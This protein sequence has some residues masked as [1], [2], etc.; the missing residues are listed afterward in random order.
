M[1]VEIA[2]AVENWARKWGRHATIGWLP[3]TPPIPQVRLTLKPDDGRLSLYREGRIAE[4]PVETV[5]LV[6]W[7]EA[8]G[9]YVGL[10]LMELG[11]G[12]VVEILDRGNSWSG[13]GEYGSLQEAVTAAAE[14]QRQT[15]ER[16][17]EYLRG[18]AR[19]LADDME[20]P[21]YERPAGYRHIPV[22]VDIG[23]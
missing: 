2:D 6:E 11:A 21:G 5:E 3:T 19:A 12:G 9:C 4:E 8:Q 15:L 16:T 22:T 23:G 7:D 18:E 1:P 10:N 20:R 13:R 14:R 17:R